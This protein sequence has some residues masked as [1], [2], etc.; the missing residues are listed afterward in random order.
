MR[1]PDRF[2]WPDGVEA[3]VSLT[4]DDGRESQLVHGLPVLDRHYVKGTFYLSPSSADPNLDAWKRVA[5]AGHE[6]GNHSLSHVCSGNFAWGCPTLEDM[7]LDEMEADIVA[8]RD[9]LAERFGRV[10][11]TFAYPCGEDFVGR[12][13]DCRSYT[14]LVAKYHIAG[15]R[16]REETFNDPSFSD[17][18]RLTGTE[19]DGCSF[20]Q[21]QRML[22][23]A[24]D[25]R[26]WI[27]LAIHD[28]GR[29]QP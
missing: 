18:A 13:E 21:L 2:A 24:R 27:V 19:G 4:L 1:Y 3:A 23:D 15:R 10:P 14:P 28:V 11:R 20:E 12:G 6:I 29:D 22:A 26:A 16:F 5:E 9:G 8:G 7:T 25:Q 17:L